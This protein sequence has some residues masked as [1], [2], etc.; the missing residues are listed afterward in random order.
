[1]S[2]RAGSSGR[3]R[4]RQERDPYVGR[5]VAEDRRS[6]AAFKLEQIQTKAR[7]IRPGAVCVDLGA[8]PGGWSQFAARAAG[9]KGAVFAIDL[10]EM[11]PIPGVTFVHGDFTDAAVREHLQSLLGG[12]PVDLVMSDMAPNISGNRATDQ[13]RSMALADAALEFAADVLNPGGAFLTK[14]FQGAGFDDY[15]R[16]ARRQFAGTRLIKPKASRPESREIYL[17]ARGYAMV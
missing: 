1:M 8:S 15:V 13:P 3:W 7:V 4:R 14:L 11:A 2:R 5:A 12:R 10:L 6:R 9:P 17:L 16:E